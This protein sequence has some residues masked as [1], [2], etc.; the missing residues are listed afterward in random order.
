MLLFEKLQYDDIKWRQIVAINYALSYGNDNLFSVW[1]FDAMLTCLK[2]IT[3]DKKQD[4]SWDTLN[5]V[6]NEKKVITK[7]PL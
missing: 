7:Y 5:E 2:L 6:Q 1:T 3:K 4:D